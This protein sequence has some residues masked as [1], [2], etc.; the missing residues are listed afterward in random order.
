MASPETMQTMAPD[1]MRAE[2]RAVAQNSVFAALAI[3][4][5][6]ADALH[7]STD[8]WSSCVVVLGLAVIVV[9]RKYGIG[10]LQ[11]ADPIAALF[12][13]MFKLYV[14]SRLGRQTIDALLDAAPVGIRN[15]IIAEV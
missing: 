15:Q 8:V 6:E 13:A 1:L 11:A 7:F 4:A 10:W 9:G 5:L 14:S 3:K 12:V 2:K